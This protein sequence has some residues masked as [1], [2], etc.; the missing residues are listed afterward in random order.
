MDSEDTLL[1]LV[2]LIYRAAGDPGKWPVVLERLVSVFQARAGTIH[3]QDSSSQDSNFSSQCGLSPDAIQLYTT[4]Y[5]YHNPFMTTR[6]QVIRTG[7]VNTLEML[8]PKE[9]L[10]RSEFYND[11][12][13]HLDLLHCVA[14]TLRNDGDNSS[15]LSLFRSPRDDPFDEQERKI[16]RT[17]MPHLQRA[18]QLHT[19]IQGLERKADAA[20]DALDQLSQGIIL[21]DARGGVLMAN[22]SASTL[23]A[24]GKT[25]HL[26]PRGLVAM[27]PSENKQLQ[28]LV[29]GAIRTAGG[30]GLHSGGAMTIS[31]SFDEKPLQLLVSPLRTQSIHIG[32]DVPVVAIF[33]ADPERKPLSQPDMLAQLY[34]LTRAES[35]LAEIL[36]GGTT[37][38][39]ACEQLGVMESTLR[40]QLK[41]IFSKTN[42]NRQSDLIRLLMLTPARAA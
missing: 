42:T 3:H 37:L 14:A 19:R 10:I 11:F 38:K 18:F 15:N 5:G 16:L 22:R 40:S 23:L 32:K 4:Y 27:I 9:L 35:R 34:G 31:R 29:K 33:I 7:A 8:C 25:L 30:Q 41:S 1:E 20:A 17:L 24:K 28:A 12:L 13:E 2:D 21:L 6:P 36:M 39:E 26:T